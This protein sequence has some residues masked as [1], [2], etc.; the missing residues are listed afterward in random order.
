MR[1]RDLLILELDSLN[2]CIEQWISILDMFAKGKKISE[3]YYKRMSEAGIDFPRASENLAADQ[4]SIDYVKNV[5]EKYQAK[6]DQ[7]LARL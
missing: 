2:R 1:E 7:V 5:I 6:R 3:D 4:K